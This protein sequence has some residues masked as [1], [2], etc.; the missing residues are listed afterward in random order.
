MVATGTCTYR[1]FGMLYPEI[2]GRN[3]SSSASKKKRRSNS[4]G[5]LRNKFAQF[6]TL[7]R[8]GALL[9]SI[10]SSKTQPALKCTYVYV[11]YDVIILVKDS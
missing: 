3:V 8:I 9:G 2:F 7:L 4:S 6:A 10:L 11:K 5:S 1:M